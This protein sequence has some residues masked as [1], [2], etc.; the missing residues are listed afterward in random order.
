MESDNAHKT[1]LRVSKEKNFNLLVL[2]FLAAA[3]TTAHSMPNVS[4]S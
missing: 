4:A 2:I 3:R 1:L